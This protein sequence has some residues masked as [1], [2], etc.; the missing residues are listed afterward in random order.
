MVK[1]KR[2]SSIELLRLLSMFLVVIHHYAIHGTYFYNGGSRVTGANQAYLLLHLAGR[3]GVAIFVLIGAYFLCMKKFDFRRPIN[4]SLTT[5]FYSWLLFI[6]FIKTKPEIVYQTF[7]G[8]V[9]IL[10]KSLFPSVLP[11]GYWFVDSYLF[12][13]LLMPVLNLIIRNLSYR[14]LGLLILFLFITESIIP[15]YSAV[16]PKP[17]F[18][19]DF[20]GFSKGTV[21]IF[22]YLL[23]AFIRKSEGKWFTEIKF[24]V[25]ILL[26]SIIIVMLIINFSHDADIYKHA[27]IFFDS[28]SPLCLMLAWS[29]FIIF[30]RVSFYSIVIN[31][32]AGSTFAVYLISDNTFV[33]DI[34]WPSIF[35]SGKAISSGLDFLSF[36]FKASAIIFISCLLIDIVIR[37]TGLNKIIT[38]LTNWIAHFVTD[39]V[40]RSLREQ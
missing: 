38:V 25:L 31:Y 19:G 33:R 20:L 15:T 8:G 10:F 6:I 12:M 14:R 13:L 32:L 40:K 4:L 7:N 27:D 35:P 18:Q 37:R 29:I 17:E 22:I 23:A 30:S 5:Y 2:N 16:Y 34:I 24:N 39:I 26:I 36:G 21:F 28:Y 1:S 9:D 3:L 11:I